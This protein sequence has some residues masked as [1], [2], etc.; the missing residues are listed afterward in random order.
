[1][2][3]LKNIVIF[4][5]GGWARE[6]LGIVEMINRQSA[7]WNILGLLD[8]DPKQHGS[9]IAGQTVLGGSDWLYEHPGI[10]LVIGIGSSI[11]RKQIAERLMVQFD[12]VFPIIIHPLA[13]VG[14]RVSLGEGSV[15]HAYS[16]ATV[17]LQMGRHNLLNVGAMVSHGNRIADYVS[18]HPH[19][20][21]SGDVTLCEGVELGTGTDVIQGANIGSYSI[22][23]AGSV[24]VKPIEACC[25]AV[26]A[27]AKPIKRLAPPMFAPAAVPLGS[28]LS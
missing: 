26:G 17:D 28:E 1:M 20:N 27:P 25:V 6:V 19:C 18:I 16:V 15:L 3:D 13:Y 5:S 8:D 4:G 10:N 14:P 9:V 23:G 11:T 7:T 12:I 22:V 2:S 24:V 21:V